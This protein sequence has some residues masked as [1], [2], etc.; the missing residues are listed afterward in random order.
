MVDARAYVSDMV[1]V[2]TNRI[3]VEAEAH[4]HFW[5]VG[6]SHGG[7]LEEDGPEF[8]EYDGLPQ[9]GLGLSRWTLKAAFENLRVYAKG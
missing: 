1:R 9:H 4:T 2:K 3:S 8:F 6:T 7:C 5:I